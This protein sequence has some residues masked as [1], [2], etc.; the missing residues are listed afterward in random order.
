M[1]S[2]ELSNCWAYASVFKSPLWVLI[3]FALGCQLPPETPGPEGQ[4]EQDEQELKSPPPPKFAPLG[5]LGGPC[6]KNH[7]G[8]PSGPALYQK[9]ASLKK[10]NLKLSSSDCSGTTGAHSFVF[11]VPRLVNDHSGAADKLRVNMTVAGYEQSVALEF[12]RNGALVGTAFRGWDEATQTAFINEY[13]GGVETILAVADPR[14]WRRITSMS[15]LNTCFPKQS[16]WYFQCGACRLSRLALVGALA[17]SGGIFGAGTVAEGASAAAAAAAA[18]RAARLAAGFAVG[19][20]VLTD[21]LTCEDTCKAEKCN[22]EV[23]KCA[24]SCPSGRAGNIC[25]DGCLGDFDLCC[26]GGGVTKTG[27][28]ECMANI[29]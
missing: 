16:V 23:A 2:T 27:A 15:R 8:C 9:F 26:R 24:G 5:S 18:D 12:F 14:L 29:L 3:P 4:E 6:G 22:E 25:F 7:D 11:D 21:T 10:S 19:A 20:Q 17:W 1:T 13:K 28:T